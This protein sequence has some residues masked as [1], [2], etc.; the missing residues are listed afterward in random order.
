MAILKVVSEQQL[1][2]ATR[3]GWELVDTREVEAICFVNRQEVVIIPAMNGCSAYPQS[4][5]KTGEEVVRSLRFVV[6]LKEESELALQAKRIVD[7]ETELTKLKNDQVAACNAAKAAKEKEEKLQGTLKGMDND[8]ML[9]R[10]NR[11]SFQE[12]VRVYET[13]FAKLRQEFGA[14]EMRRITGR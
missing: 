4:V 9:V 5:S 11:D 13:D 2:E 12:K 10:A 1:E 14:A 3:Q 6:S 8:L 7:Q